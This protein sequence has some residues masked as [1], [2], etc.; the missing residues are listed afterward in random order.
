MSS[1]YDEKNEPGRKDEK[2][3][4]GQQGPSPSGAKEPGRESNVPREGE[5]GRPGSGSIPNP[6]P[7]TDESESDAS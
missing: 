7:S 2:S 1:D 3:L 5:G 4:G 6:K